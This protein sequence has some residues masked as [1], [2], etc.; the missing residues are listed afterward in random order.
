MLSLPNLNFKP[1]RFSFR[2]FIY[3]FFVL[4]ILVLLAEGGYYFWTQ[5]R[6]LT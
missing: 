2:L 3:F 6:T 1:P 5:K 4:V